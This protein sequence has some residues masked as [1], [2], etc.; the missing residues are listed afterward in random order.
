[1]PLQLSL[2]GMWVG[3]ALA[4][5]ALWLAVAED[6]PEATPASY[7]LTRYTAEQGLPQNSIRALLQTR[8]GY[9][10]IGTL[11]GLARFDGVEVQGL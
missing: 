1:M 4:G 3:T 9:L 2:R 7:S 8:D 5:V 11:A 6:R 10:W